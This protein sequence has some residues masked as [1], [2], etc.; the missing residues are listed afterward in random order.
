M[1]D[2]VLLEEEAQVAVVEVL[3]QRRRQRQHVGR[4]VAD[5]LS[6]L[7]LRH[8]VADHRLVD[9]EVDEAH[10]GVG[11]AAH[12]L[13]VDADQLQ[14]GDQREARR[15]HPRAVPQ[16]FDVARVEQPLAFERGAEDDEDALDQL[17]LEAGLAG[18]VLD[19]DLLLGPRE[20]V[21]GEAE[22]EPTLAT[23]P[24]SSSSEWPRS[25]IR[26]TTR[27]CAAAAAVQRPR[28]T[29]TTLSAAQ[30]FSVLAET[31]ERRA[32]SLRDMRSSPAIAAD[33]FALWRRAAAPASHVVLGRD[34]LLRMGL[35]DGLAR[36]RRCGS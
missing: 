9:V 3:G 35:E 16:R 31:P 24:R 1:A 7:Q 6:H 14:E 21:L 29:G 2:D 32:A 13:D 10:L 5:L 34:L 12:R 11:D 26:A 27:A 15:Q 25:R 23:R 30:R 17:G 33:S 4:E 8:A 36:P 19:R 20:E 28:R 18:H 22:R